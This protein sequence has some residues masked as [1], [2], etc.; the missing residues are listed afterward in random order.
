MKQ[1]LSRSVAIG[2]VAE[3]DLGKVPGKTALELQA[4]A[5]IAALRDAGLCLQD[6]DAVFAH[7]DDRFSS[8]QVA[9]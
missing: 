3:S 6:V 5:A 1:T 7:T 9:E 2:G 8:L 4:Q